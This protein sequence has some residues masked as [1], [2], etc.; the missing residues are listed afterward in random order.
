MGGR[1][2]SDIFWVYGSNI[3]HITGEQYIQ[4]RRP[5][6]LCRAFIIAKKSKEGL[7]DRVRLSLGESKSKITISS[8]I[9]WIMFYM[10]DNGIDTILRVYN[11]YLKTKVYLIG[12]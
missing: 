8:W 12:D 2:K 5:N 9:D 7:L 3:F 4:T 6:E 11:T 1:Q 10:E